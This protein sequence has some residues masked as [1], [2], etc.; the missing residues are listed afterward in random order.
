MINILFLVVG[1]FQFCGKCACKHNIT[2]I[3]LTDTSHTLEE[4]APDRRLA[5]KY[6]KH[7]AK[8]LGHYEISFLYNNI[9]ILLRSHNGWCVRRSVCPVRVRCH[10]LHVQWRVFLRH[11]WLDTTHEPTRAMRNSVWSGIV[12]AL[13]AQPICWEQKCVQPKLTHAAREELTAVL[14]HNKK[15]H[16]VEMSMNGKKGISSEHKNDGN[17]S[18]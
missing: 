10:I 13:R 15:D 11:K 8:D 17:H 6:T 2:H 16:N 12:N 14:P 4:V 7:H 9:I 3:R 5:N 1:F 18:I